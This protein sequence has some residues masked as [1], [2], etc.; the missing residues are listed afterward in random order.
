MFKKQMSL[1]L[2]PLLP[3][4]AFWI[5]QVAFVR[6]SDVDHYRNMIRQREIA[7]SDV[8]SP[9][10]QHR[11]QVRKDIWFAQ[12]DCTRL[13][14]QIASE[15]SLLSLTPV[16]NKFDVIESLQGV[17]CWMQEKLSTDALGEEPIQQTRLIEAETGVYRY[18]DQEFKADNV[19]LSLFKL[20]GHDLPLEP[21]EKEDAFL[22]GIAENISFVFSGKTPQF[23]AEHFEA[24]AVKE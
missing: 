7:S 10:N 14:Y 15:G 1:L 16:K 11:K 9:T 19:L 21:I 23:Q 5:Y 13:H 22:R 12:S 6:S 3:I 20:P 8:R 2:I 18:S 17:K 24:T 4:T